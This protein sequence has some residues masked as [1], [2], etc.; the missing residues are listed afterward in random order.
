M[1]WAIGGM[2]GWV[3]YDFSWHGVLCCHK[4][5]L[6]RGQDSRFP[7]KEPVLIGA[8]AVMSP[9]LLFKRWISLSSWA[10]S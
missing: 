2:K 3:L 9:V 6:L 4:D 10:H 1:T 7:L 5:Q 8:V